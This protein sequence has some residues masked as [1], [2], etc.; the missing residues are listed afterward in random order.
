MQPLQYNEF[1]CK[2]FVS[3]MRPGLVIY[4]AGLVYL[5]QKCV[6]EHKS[7]SQRVMAHARLNILSL[8]LTE[9]THCHGISSLDLHLQAET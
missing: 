2:I 9:S 5:C 3:Q 8:F 6:D 1:R 7:L 4:V